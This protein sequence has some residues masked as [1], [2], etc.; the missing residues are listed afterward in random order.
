V[1]G[2]SL[3]TDAP[4]IFRALVEATAF[5]AKAIADRFRREGVPI[6]GVIA[7]G[8]VAKKSPFIMQIVSDVMNV[9]IRVPRAEQTCALGAA[10]FAGVVAGLYP[11]LADAM[12]AMESGWE[13]E[14]TPRAEYA[15]I[16]AG[17][18]ER[19]ASLARFVEDETMASRRTE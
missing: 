5:G 19:Y 7:L 10:M 15:R 6:N 11:T 1:T 9:P 3:G 4:R 12:K 8:G 13:R 16:Y 17:L 2:L 14:Y 18:Y